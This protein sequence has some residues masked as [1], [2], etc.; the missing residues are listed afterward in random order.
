MCSVS[1]EGSKAGEKQLTEINDKFVILTR[2]YA[3]NAKM[4]IAQIV[5]GSRV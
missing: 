4:S 3:V 5:A 2:V 1:E